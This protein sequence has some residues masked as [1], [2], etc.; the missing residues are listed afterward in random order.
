MLIDSHCHLNFNAFKNDWK[1]II[2][3]CLSKNIWM[4][5]VGTKYETSKK[6]VEIAEEFSDGVFAAIGLH[7]IHLEAQKY[8]AWELGG[9]NG[10]KTIP[11]EFVYERYKKLAKS[12]KKVVAIGEIGL[13]YWRKPKTKRKLE[14]FKRK[15]K[16]TLKEQIKLA[17][18]L[19]LPVIFHCRVAFD[20]LLKVLKEEFERNGE[21][22]G[23][24]HSFTG[25]W[26][27]AKDF[28]D[29][30]F[31]LGFNGIIFKLN[32]E[33]V[34]RRVPLEKTI[35]ETDSP[36]LVPPQCKKERNDPCCVKRIAEELS[37]IKKKDL[38]KIA[39]ITTYNT[40]NLFGL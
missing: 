7:P 8:D 4:V 11:E 34:I 21:I 25:D 28:L 39:E 33:E 35:L 17:R 31:Y 15:Q 2:E 29:M 1:E 30:G 22:K 20:D 24:I 6:A 14:E 9:G 27:T 23:V 13:D 3:N 38:K 32:L 40:K 5:N 10:L 26:Q 37:Q 18:E 16:D 19:N 36:Y 12:S